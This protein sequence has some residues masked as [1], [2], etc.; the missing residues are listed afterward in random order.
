MK[1][2]IG[3]GFLTA[4]LTAMPATSYA[5][6]LA[7]TSK[8]VNLRAGPSRD[9]P[10][11]ATLPAGVSIS[12]EGCLSDYRWC[13]VVAGPNRGWVYAGNI[14]YPYQGSTVPV[15][16]YGAMIGIGII[17]F[18]IGNYWD[19]H[20]RASPWYPQR[21]RWIDRPH[22]AFGLDGH[23]LPPLRPGF[24]PDGG[25]RTPQGQRPGDAQRPSHG[26]G[27]IGGQRPPQGQRPGGAQRSP[28]GQGPSGGQR[29]PQRQRPDSGQQP[30]QGQGPGAGA[31]AGHRPRQGRLPED[32]RNP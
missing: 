3:L 15:L 26:Q 13:D 29:P 14:V 12:V 19:D 22:P 7:Y 1:Y 21:Q 11:V 23:R 18:S 27:P 20:Y 17:A 4:A 10:V 31:G 6:Q 8:D 16:T 9:Y 30:P 2:V 25:Q 32:V 24:G 28:L 5:Q